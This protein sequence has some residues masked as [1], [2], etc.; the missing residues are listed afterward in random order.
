MAPN[1][2]LWIKADAGVVLSGTAV[3]AWK[4]QVGI[5]D[6]TQSASAS[7][8]IYRTSTQLINFN[9]T[10]DFDGSNDYFDGS[11]N[12]GVSGAT[13]FTTFSVARRTTDNS[14]DMLWGSSF[15]GDPGNQPS[16]YISDTNTTVNDTITLD[17]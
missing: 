10:I 14:L 16:F 3:S 11:S 9:P 2:T 6:V 1:N 7:Q 5:N 12:Y 15:P 17:G 8:P 13:L 4:N